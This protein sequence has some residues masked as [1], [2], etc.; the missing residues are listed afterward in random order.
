[1]RHMQIIESGDIHEARMRY[2]KGLQKQNIVLD[3][4]MGI[5]IET[6]HRSIPG[7]HSWLCYIAPVMQHAA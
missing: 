4:T 1:M 3:Q 7:A 2:L 6:I 5:Y